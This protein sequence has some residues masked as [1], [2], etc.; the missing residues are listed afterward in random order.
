MTDG[1]DLGMA[2]ANPGGWPIVAPARLGCPLEKSEAASSNNSAALF[3]V[4]PLTFGRSG[5]TPAQSPKGTQATG[6]TR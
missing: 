2:A 4:P 3:G 6:A 5:G 1:G